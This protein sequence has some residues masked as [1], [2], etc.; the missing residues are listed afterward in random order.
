MYKVEIIT[1]WIRIVSD[2]CQVFSK[3]KC[4]CVMIKHQVIDVLQ[5]VYVFF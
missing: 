3:S 5:T 4:D 2:I 1:V